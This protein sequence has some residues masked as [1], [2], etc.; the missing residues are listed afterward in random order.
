MRCLLSLDG[1]SSA[2]LLLS[3]APTNPL[4]VASAISC[5]ADDFTPWELFA[6]S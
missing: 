5:A 3:N 4:A 6:T 2:F 1:I